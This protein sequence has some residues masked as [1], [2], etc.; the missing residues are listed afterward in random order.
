MKKLSLPL[1]DL[2]GLDPRSDLTLLT[3]AHHFL[4]VTNIKFTEFI[5]V[6]FSVPTINLLGS[7]G[8]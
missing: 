5:A 4:L 8:E 1:S 7:G 6:T 2:P 3:T